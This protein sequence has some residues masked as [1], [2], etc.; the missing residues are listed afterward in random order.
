MYRVGIIGVGFIG[1]VHAYG[2]RN[3]SF[4]YDPVPLEAE[5]THVV[6]SRPET[7]EKARQVVGA[8]PR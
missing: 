1:K 6:T 3:L 4:Y 7:A 8:S 2:Y 5:I